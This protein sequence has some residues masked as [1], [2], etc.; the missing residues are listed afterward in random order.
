MVPLLRT[1]HDGVHV[2]RDTHQKPPP[3]VYHG[4]KK[5]GVNDLCSMMLSARSRSKG[6]VLNA[7][8]CLLDAL[9]TNSRTLFK[10][11]TNKNLL[12][13]SY[14][15]NLGKGFGVLFIQ[16]RYQDGFGI[17]KFSK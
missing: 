15:W 4:H 9:R 7:S 3:F 12:N 5:S 10:E 14:T 1:M 16:S 17:N 11:T 8:F 2:S 13:F 6:W